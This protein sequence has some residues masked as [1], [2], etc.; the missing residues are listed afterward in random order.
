M[1]DPAVP[2]IAGVLLV[3]WWPSGADGDWRTAPHTAQ[4]AL[5]HVCDA[6]ANRGFD[7]M[8]SDE[9]TL[10]RGGERNGMSEVLDD[11]DARRAAGARPDDHIFGI[12]AG[13]SL[14]DS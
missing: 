10:R 14:A 5:R 9:A 4:D 13:Q 1:T 7:G 11:L 8:E 2:C 12:V 6:D 3:V